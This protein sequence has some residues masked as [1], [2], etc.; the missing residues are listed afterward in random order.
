MNP[1]WMG[2]S[3]PSC[4]RPSTVR[5][6]WPPAIAASTVQDF[7]GSPSNHTTQVPQLLV[8]QPQW[9]P[10][11]PIVSRRKCT[12]SSR[13]SISRVYSSPLTVIDTCM[14]GLPVDTGHGPAQ[15]PPREFVGQVT[16]VL[17]GAAHVG[18]RT[19]ALG[20]D[21]SG[22]LVQLFRGDLA[23]QGVR[24]RWEAG[25]VGPDR[26][27]AD[28]GIGDHFAVHPDRGPG[29]HDGPVAGASLDLLVGA[30]TVGPQREANLGED[31]GFADRRLVG[32]AVEL[33]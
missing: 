2:S 17:L 23:A 18:D 16:L 27:Q 29:R 8:S 15:R 5:T 19:A 14:S 30:R 25:R 3:A 6:S 9:V 13:P 12:S 26:G 20:R 32:T 22:L 21:R 11:S 1:F 7:T 33:L 28:A 31:L 10:V 4:S 24:D